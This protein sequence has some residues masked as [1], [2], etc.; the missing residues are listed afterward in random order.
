[1]TQVIIFFGWLMIGIAVTLVVFGHVSIA[2]VYDLDTLLENL[3]PEEGLS[4]L[5]YSAA[6]LIPGSILISIGKMMNKFDDRA[7]AREAAEAGEAGEA[8]ATDADA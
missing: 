6:A 3:F 5:V 8:D 1:M 7:E 4:S 2:F